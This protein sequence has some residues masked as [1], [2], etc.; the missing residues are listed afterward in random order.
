MIYQHSGKM[1]LMLIIDCAS[2]RRA[3]RARQAPPSQCARRAA[4]AM[5]V[6]ASDG[7]CGG[8]NRG[9]RR[10]VREA[11]SATMHVGQLHHHLVLV[12]LRLQVL[13]MHHGLQPVVPVTDGV[14]GAAGQ[15]LCNLVPAVAGRQAGGQ[16]GVG[17]TA[18][19][20][21]AGCGALLVAEFRG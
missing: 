21:E 19:A 9:H 2:R 16:A 3:P 17:A 8:A 11:R 12:L 1:P 18:R 5:L 4:G 14:I 6:E 7:E 13:V 10:R 20:P 15:P